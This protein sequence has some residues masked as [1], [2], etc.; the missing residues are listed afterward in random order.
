MS[1]PGSSPT[2]KSLGHDE[3]Y[4]LTDICGRCTDLNFV[5]SSIDDVILRS[6]HHTVADLWQSRPQTSLPL[7][8]PAQARRAPPRAN[9]CV[10]ATPSHR[11]H[12]HKA[13]PLRPRFAC[14]HS[15]PAT[16]PSPCR[17]HPPAIDPAAAPNTRSA[18][19]TIHVRTDTAPRRR[20]IDTCGPA[21]CSRR[22]AATSRSPCRTSPATARTDLRRRTAR[23]LAQFRR[24]APDTTRP[25]SPAD[26]LLPNRWPAPIPSSGPARPACRL[27]ATTRGVSA[28]SQAAADRCDRRR[29]SRDSS[30]SFPRLRRRQSG[31]R[32]IRSR[33]PAAQH[34]S[35]RRTAVVRRADAMQGVSRH[36][37]C[38]RNIR[39][40]S[41]R[42]CP[43]ADRSQR[44]GCASAR[45]PPS[46]RSARVRRGTS[47]S[48]RSLPRQ[49]RSDP[50]PAVTV[51]RSSAR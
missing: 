3:G 2:C 41:R 49:S 44:C 13:A 43:L 38:L 33:R 6:G 31:R 45:W 36:R 23:R 32:R 11:P 5:A 12:A 26:A 15:S 27:R 17:S 30:P 4:S 22:T 8:R 19:T 46:R 16:T 1:S 21:S 25:R 34:P 18:N 29:R 39:A 51:D 48:H 10:R 40:A 35:L 37:E 20:S 42:L 14:R 24:V 47:E 28:D 7:I 50:T 9:P